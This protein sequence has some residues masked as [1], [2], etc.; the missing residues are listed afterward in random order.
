MIDVSEIG[1][2]Q[3]HQTLAILCSFESGNEWF[4]V[5]PILRTLI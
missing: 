2:P 4:W 3:N 5:T 1:G